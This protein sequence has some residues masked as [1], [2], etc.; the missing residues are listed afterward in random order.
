MD[1]KTGTNT[2]FV[3]LLLLFVATSI[4]VFVLSKQ[5]SESLIRTMAIESASLY[6]DALNEFRSV[7]SSEVINRLSDKPSNEIRHDY[8]DHVNAVPLPATLS[9]LL[10]RNIGEHLSGA[11]T[12]LYSP[13]PFPWRESEGINSDFR[14]KAWQTLS[15]APGKP[16]YEFVEFEGRESIRFAVADVMRVSCVEC[17][18][19]HPDTPKSDWQV[20]DVRGVLEVI[21][22]LDNIIQQ[23]D[24]STSAIQLLVVV[25][26]IFGLTSILFFVLQ[27]KRNNKRLR[28]K[29][30]DTKLKVISSQENLA[31]SE[32]LAALGLVSVGIAHEINQ[33]LGAAKLTLEMLAKR[34]EAKGFGIED[35]L[36]RMIRQI[37][38]IDGIIKQL[39]VSTRDTGSLKPESVDLN[40]LGKRV[41]T[42]LADELAAEDIKLTIALA[43]GLP[44][45]IANEVEI[46]RV[47][48]NLMTNAM[49]AM[50]DLKSPKV[51]TLESGYDDNT[52]W[53][54]IADTGNG[55]PESIRQKI[56][57][58]FFTT[59]EVGQ[60]MGM[61]LSLC[62]GIVQK[63]D[64][65][66]K[67]KSSVS[68]P[69]EDDLV[70]SVS[71]SQFTIEFKRTSDSGA[72]NVN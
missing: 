28:A 25:A 69:N 31:K 39:N 23:A 46:E 48:T 7:Y 36:G 56:F 62:R 8:A 41:T 26:S 35:K 34:N 2:L 72:T 30:K 60:G 33:P 66:I 47:I 55:V 13:F 49:H 44:K 63:Y 53:L 52:I 29:L 45:I 27:E 57:D 50:R 59:K 4:A 1:R 20:G 64:G 51:I 40:D 38:R 14:K 42:W 71:G 17:H 18:N 43:E 12:Y 9:M 65:E 3:I 16:Y 58:P 22:P 67:L 32:K 11:H 68:S 24:E 70:K 61:G 21:Q 5:I 54:S 10:G 6:S 15:N 19:Q 37:D